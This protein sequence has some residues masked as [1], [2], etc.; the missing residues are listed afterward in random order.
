MA[1]FLLPAPGRIPSIA[2]SFGNDTEPELGNPTLL[3]RNE[4]AKY[5]FTFI[6]ETAFQGRLDP[7]SSKD[8]SEV[9]L[10]EKVRP[11]S[12]HCTNE[13]DERLSAASYSLSDREH[14]C[15]LNRKVELSQKGHPSKDHKV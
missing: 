5:D 4:L 2:G 12:P 1:F 6:A 8:G 15:E 7:P 3:P 14:F 13:T 10:N 11:R 9:L